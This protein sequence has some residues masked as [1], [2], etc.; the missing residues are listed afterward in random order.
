MIE[1]GEDLPLGQ[2]AAVDL[3]GIHAALDELESDLLLELAVGPLGQVDRAH[4]AAG[5]LT[6]HPVGP[7]AD[8]LERGAAVLRLEQGG[9]KHG[10]GRFEKIL[11]RRVSYSSA[12]SPP[13]NSR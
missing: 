12:G 3:L 9:G 1:S 2:K 4:A 13:P 11:H 7:D 6:E 5:Q 8:S 10:G